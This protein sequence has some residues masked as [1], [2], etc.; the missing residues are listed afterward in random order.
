MS[1]GHVCSSSAVTCWRR[2]Y[3]AEINLRRR[4]DRAAARGVQANI[5]AVNSSGVE[6]PLERGRS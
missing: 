5:D 2:C 4:R 1:G 3:A 6:H